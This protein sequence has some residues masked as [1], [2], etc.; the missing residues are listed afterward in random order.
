[1]LHDLAVLRDFFP[2][3]DGCKQSLSVGILKN[4]VKRSLSG[5]IYVALIVACVILGGWW[6]NALLLLFTIL[7]VVEFHSLVDKSV[8]KKTSVVPLVTDLLA[9][10]ALVL[11]MSYSLAFLAIFILCLIVR[12]IAQLYI[13]EDAP[14]VRLAYSYMGVFY[15]ALPLG[16][17]GFIMEMLGEDSAKALLL[18]M[19]VMIWLNDTGAF[20]VGSSMGRHKL[21]PSVSPKKSWEGAIGGV[22]FSIGAAFV[23]KYCF[24]DYF[25]SVTIVQLCVMGLI[26]GIISIWGDLVESMIKRTL[27]V[28]DSGNLIPGHGGI[29]DRIDSLLLVAPAVAVYFFIIFWCI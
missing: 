15:I 28:K 11:G 24:P 25:D 13:H 21:F 27:H 17:L 22:I 16:L 10:V 12:L 29:L 18:T 2:N 14:L 5:I 8:S 7:G 9:S 26:V 23:V 3:F 19:F 1:M 4:L 20:L 6:F